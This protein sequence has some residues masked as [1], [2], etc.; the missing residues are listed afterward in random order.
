MKKIIKVLILSI[1]LVI[2]ICISPIQADTIVPLCPAGTPFNSSLYP[3]NTPW[4]NPMVFTCTWDGTGQ[5]YISG[6]ENSLTGVY[7]DDGF[8][9]QIEPSG[10]SF[11]APEHWAHQHPIV[12]LTSGM[13]PGTN[14]FTLVVQNW[15]GLSM[16]YGMGNGGAIPA[17]VMQTPYIIEVIPGIGSG[18]SGITANQPS[19]IVVT[20]KISPESIKQ[21]TNATINITVSNHGKTPVHDVE[22]L[23]TT[24][25]AFPVVNGI[26]QLSASSIEPN[27]SIILTYTVQAKEPGLFSLNKTSVM[28]AEPDGNYY[29]IY[30]NPE[31][32]DVLVPLIATPSQDGSDN[33]IQDLFTW[34]K[35]LDPFVQQKS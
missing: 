1:S 32:V 28:Y 19:E 7:A 4:S 26:T 27:D 34:I 9:I 13:T 17:G 8:T 29:L 25:P 6:D 12:N 11:D 20:K 18:S 22:I 5:V 14:T 35:G 33:F 21:D 3:Q 30:S 31:T 24:L 15:D 10:A 16:S 2:I 23:D